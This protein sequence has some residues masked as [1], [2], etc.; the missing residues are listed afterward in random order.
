MELGMNT[1]EQATNRPVLTL[2]NLL[3]NKQGKSENDPVLEIAVDPEKEKFILST[4]SDELCVGEYSFISKDDGITFPSIDFE[5]HHD[6]EELDLSGLYSLLFHKAYHYGKSLQVIQRGWRDSDGFLFEIGSDKREGTNRG[7]DFLQADL[8]DGMFQAV[9]AVRYIR[10]RDD[11]GLYLP[12]MIK[13]LSILE[14]MEAPCFVYIKKHDMTI[15]DGNIMAELFV[16]DKDG[17][18]AMWMDKVIFKKVA[19]NH[20]HKN[21]GIPETVSDND[22]LD[23]E[24]NAVFSIIKGELTSIISSKLELNKEDIIDDKSFFDLGVDSITTQEIIEELEKTYER[25]P[26]TL[27]FEYPDIMSLAS[28]LVTKLPEEKVAGLVTSNKLKCAVPDSP[29]CPDPVTKPIMPVPCSMKEAS[30]NDVVEKDRIHR[31]YDIAIIGISGRFPKAGDLRTYWKN[32]ITG[33]DCIEE[34]PRG[35]WDHARYYDPVPGHSNKTYGKWGGFIEDY[36]KF[37]PLFFNISPREAEQ[38]DPQQRLFLEC[39]WEVMED[40]GY[41]DRKR[42]KDKKTGVYVG[43]QWNEYSQVSTE[44]GFVNDAYVG[45]G[46]LYWAIPNRISYF[47]DF[48]GAEYCR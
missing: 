13:C 33:L 20:L 22:I 36:D 46:S 35:R 43:L 2:N 21:D 29:P 7:S 31:G 41:G 5:S 32:L 48:T 26:V 12:C 11:N 39:A 1:I 25:L 8:M 16:Y 30:R 15:Q 14:P 38:M 17:N 45:P 3:F 6:K 10:E 9:L 18:K 23:D 27:L 4:P 28:F 44:K 42:N 47:M 34:I 37:D 19:E 40:A 24:K